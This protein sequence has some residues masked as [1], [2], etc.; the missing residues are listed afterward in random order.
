MTTPGTAASG[1]T[2]LVTGGARGIGAGIAVAATAAGYRVAITYEK[3]RVEAD[4]LVA[5]GHADLALQ[6]DAGDPEAIASTFRAVLDRYGCLDVLV[7]NAGI[8]GAYGSIDVVTAEML[9]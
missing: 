7:N 3:S 1:R 8:G 6:S 9:E 4:Q 5:D 2:M